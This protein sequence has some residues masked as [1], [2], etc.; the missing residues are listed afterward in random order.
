MKKKTWTETER[1]T[2]TE[3]RGER[4]GVCVDTKHVCDDNYVSEQT[5][6]ANSRKND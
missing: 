4:G 3:R 6:Y 5:A 1:Q 2:E